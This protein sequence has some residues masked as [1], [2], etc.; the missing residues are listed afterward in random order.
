[1]ENF[2]FSFSF[3]YNDINFFRD[4]IEEQPSFKRDINVIDSS[5]LEEFT[6]D[7]EEKLGS[8]YKQEI[9]THMLVDK[10][11]EQL[12]ELTKTTKQLQLSLLKLVDV[13]KVVNSCGLGYGDKISDSYLKMSDYIGHIKEQFNDKLHFFDSDAFTVFNYLSLEYRN[14]MEFVKKAKSY[15]SYT[16][17]IQNGISIVE[18][19]H[20]EKQL[21]LNVFKAY[22]THMIHFNFK[23]LYVIKNRK[24]NEKLFDAMSREYVRMDTVS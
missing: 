11:K 17:K 19:D 24:I 12:R 18:K 16:K 21:D 20:D 13:E 2:A 5:K 4:L 8:V 15:R 3:K 23:H 1:M 22:L 14:L 9:K 7:I 6:K 10:I